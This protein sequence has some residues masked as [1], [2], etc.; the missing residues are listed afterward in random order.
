[1]LHPTLPLQFVE[2]KRPG[3]VRT[4]LQK[5]VAKDLTDA[6]FKVIC[7][8]LDDVEVI[9]NPLQIHEEFGF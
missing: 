4:Q 8:T 3:E 7:V 1:M 2:Y 9:E 6:G 5:K